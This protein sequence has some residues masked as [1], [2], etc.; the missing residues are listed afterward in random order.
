MTRVDS[1]Q[2]FWQLS[3]GD[4]SW[5]TPELEVLYRDF[6]PQDL[7]SNLISNKVEQTVLVQAAASVAETEFMLKIADE[8]DFVAGVVGWLDMESDKAIMQ[9]DAF[10]QNP[11]FKGIRPMIQDIE[12]PNWMLKPELDPVYLALI[13][14]ELTFDALVTPS[15]LDALY[16]LLTRY[17]TLKVVIDHGAKP[18]IAAYSSG[19]KSSAQWFEKIALIASET[20]AHCKLSGLVTEAGENPD[21]SSVASYMEHLLVCFGA[22]RLMWGS[23]WPVVYLTAIYIYWLNNIETFL[24]P[25]SQND[26]QLIW[27]ENAQRF[28]RL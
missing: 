5:L 13:E 2:H 24:A 22:N 8:T 18:D 4:Y 14:R 27:S 21:Y 28:Y 11:H 10:C 17:P 6:L 3:R 26:Q 9:L 16:E 15:H 19:E 12:D 7:K 20:S 1:H 25:L 23:D